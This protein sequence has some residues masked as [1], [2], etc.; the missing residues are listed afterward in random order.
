M[1]T[2]STWTTGD[3]AEVLNV[4]RSADS[5]EPGLGASSARFERWSAGDAHRS[6]G[7]RPPALTLASAHEFFIE[8][9]QPIQTDAARAMPGAAAGGRHIRTTHL[10]A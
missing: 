8:R 5:R 2:P 1:V 3:K 6:S 9:G 4:E 7:I 10:D